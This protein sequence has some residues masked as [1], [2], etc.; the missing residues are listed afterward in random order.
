MARPEVVDRDPNPKSP[1]AFEMAQDPPWVVHETSFCQL[2][3]E[4]PRIVPDLTGERFE[5]T[6]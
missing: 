1:K 6:E 3:L 5:F 2:E 4:E